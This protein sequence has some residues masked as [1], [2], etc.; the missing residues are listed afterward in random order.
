MSIDGGN[1]TV[2]IK[3]NATQ[4]VTEL[5]RAGAATT[6]F[7]NRVSKIGMGLT[8]GVTLPLIAAAGA[9]T[10]LAYDFE[11]TLTKVHALTGASSADIT[12]YRAAILGMSHDLGTAPQE[13]AKALYF[14]ANPMYTAAET[15]GIMTQAAKAAAS[16]LG[17]VEAVAF[18][19]NS[20]VM[21]YGKANLTGSYAVDILTAATREGNFEAS[22][23][24]NSIGD[25]IGSANKMSVP[26]HDVAAAI[27][28]MTK[29]GI[30]V[31]EAT[32]ALNQ[33]L[34]NL[35]KPT[36]EG[37]DFVAKLGLSFADLRKEVATKGLLPTM[38][39][40]QTLTKGNTEDMVKLIPNVRA[41]R[42]IWG[43]LGVTGSD[44]D[45]I[46]KEITNSVGDTNAAMAITAATPAF[47]MRTA[48][49]D[50]KTAATQLGEVLLPEVAKIATGVGNA[51][52]AFSRLSSASM[53]SVVRFGLLLGAVGPATLVMGK[54]TTAVLRLA[55]GVRT[56][57]GTSAVA[58]GAVPG[59]GVALL[60]IEATVVGATAW[61]ALLADTIHQ[62]SVEIKEMEYYQRKIDEY[63]ASRHEVTLQHQPGY[64]IPPG[65]PK[66]KPG[67]VKVPR[68]PSAYAAVEVGKLPQSLQINLNNLRK[69]AA[70]EIKLGHFSGKDVNQTNAQIDAL[71]KKLP[72]AM[73]MSKT[74]TDRILR[75]I[76]P[77]WHPDKDATSAL[78]KFKT[79]AAGTAQ[80]ARN[81]MVANMS[82]IHFSDVPAP[83]ITGATAS[84][85][86]ARQQMLNIFGQPMTQVVRVLLNGPSAV[87]PNPYPTYYKHAKGTDVVVD[88]PYLFMAGEGGN[89]ERVTVNPLSGPN[90][91]RYPLTTSGG[92]YGPAPV[93]HN[94]FNFNAP[95]YGVDD[96]QH[97]I[98]EAVV[99]AQDDLARA[100]LHASRVSF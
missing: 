15:L 11:T 72:A 100:D 32:T 59:I 85:Q 70:K 69:E 37:A 49:V 86:A 50:L 88:K 13:L 34:M 5:G 20:A 77:N 66:P 30:G 65:P 71:A 36:K 90:A 96:L 26:F 55:G 48:L 23:L 68:L 8:K 62:G 46:F 18:A 38:R 64:V 24:S 52:A 28:V 31:P 99:D 84:A 58:A 2:W 97:V 39:H 9:A 91:N 25:V 81:A 61:F 94:V 6:S 87:P 21:A 40:L 60:G 93:I 45:R 57:G 54:A 89:R 4:L 22:Q 35:N 67:A 63:W 53:G 73:G 83:K 92:S 27:A 1:V 79:K 41:L 51:A 76:F 95:I 43:L 75:S 42:A 74:E 82:G 98:R 7:G 10:K 47:K 29:A 33:F 78:S 44:V 3:G 16:G 14:V 17:D 56:L 19:A 80:E 12:K